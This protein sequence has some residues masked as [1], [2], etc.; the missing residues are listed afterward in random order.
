MGATNP[1]G[2]FTS[3]FFVALEVHE[4]QCKLNWMEMLD[5]TKQVLAD[6]DAKQEVAL[7]II[8]RIK[9]EYFFEPM[10]IWWWICIVFVLMS[11]MASLTLNKQAKSTNKQNKQ[12]KQNK[13]GQ[14]N[15]AL[16]I[17]FDNP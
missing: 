12:T 16:S 8:N 3:S 9:K 13:R 6:I 4:T 10:G 5:V 2:Y 11:F 7:S 14:L 15:E 1:S 17:N